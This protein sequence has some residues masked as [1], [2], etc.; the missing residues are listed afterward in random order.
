MKKILLAFLCLF[1]LYASWSVPAVAQEV[2]TTTWGTNGEVLAISRS[3]NTIYLGGSFDY[4]GPNTGSGVVLDGTNGTATGNPSPQVAGPTRAVVPDGKGG[5][6]I[7]GS[8]KAVQ[9]KTRNGLAHL[10]PDGSL[11]PAF[12]PG[13]L[14]PVGDPTA[15][16][17]TL[18]LAGN[19]LYVGGYFS[20]V[21]GQGRRNIA[22]LDA[23]TGQL[24]D[25]QPDNTST[26][27]D[28]AVR[29]IA[30]LGDVVY[31]GGHFRW[32]GQKYRFGLAALDAHTGTVMYWGPGPFIE[33]T[34]ERGDC[35]SRC[36]QYPV[37]RR[38]QW[39]Q[40][41]RMLSNNLVALDAAT[42]AP[43]DWYPQPTGHIHALAVAGDVVYVGG[44]FAT[45]G[46]QPR[47]GIAALDI[48]TGQ[49]RSGIL[50]CGSSRTLGYRSTRWPS[51]AAGSTRAVIFRQSASNHSTIPPPLTLPPASW[52]VT[53]TPAR[54][55]GCKPWP[56]PAIR[57]L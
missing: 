10:L 56:R 9:G 49:R 52:P 6:Y 13:V 2:D 23:T 19:T 12:S 30:V 47:N 54:A 1:A 24:K 31:V 42:G 41:L 17:L 38:A 16:V 50:N 5:W 39:Q 45:I 18:A 48:T 25:W 33:K 4:V 37:R 27:V 22:A 55:D 46:G 43:K 28:G 29:A 3:G 44:S 11:D 15:Y 21:N 32:I 57:Y 53:G 8:I 26:G 35:I 20:T 36:Q 34:L 14:N 7:G 40:L 51:R